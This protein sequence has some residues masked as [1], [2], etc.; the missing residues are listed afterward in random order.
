MI[1]SIKHIG[2]ILATKPLH[3]RYYTDKQQ[4]MYTLSEITMDTNTLLASKKYLLGKTCGQ[5]FISC[6]GYLRF[7]SLRN[8][9]GAH[10]AL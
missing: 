9:E 1:R 10:L 4:F 8:K 2:A 5:I 3:W 7:L 6:F